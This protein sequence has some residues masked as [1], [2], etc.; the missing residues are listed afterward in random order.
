MLAH[1]KILDTTQDTFKAGQL[2]KIYCYSSSEQDVNDKPKALC[3]SEPFSGIYKV[4]GQTAA[5]L[6]KHILQN[7]DG[8]CWHTL[9][10]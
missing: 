3:I 9:K 10:W 2:C 1:F 8:K 5:V 6:S 7:T 4:E